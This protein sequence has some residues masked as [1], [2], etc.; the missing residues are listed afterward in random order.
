MS[1]E[2]SSSSSNAH[3]NENNMVGNSSLGEIIS[4]VNDIFENEVLVKS[5]PGKRQ[6]IGYNTEGGSY[7]ID[8]MR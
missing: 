2:K 6:K 7:A 4:I 1:L 5:R 8:S 3:S